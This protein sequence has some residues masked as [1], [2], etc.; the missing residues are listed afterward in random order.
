MI[1][2]TVIEYLSESLD[3]PVSIEKPCEVN[4]YVLIE[5]IGSSEENKIKTTTIAIQSYAETMYRAAM[6][7]EE[8]KTAMEGLNNIKNISKVQFN[9]DYNYTDTATKEYR[10]QAIYDLVYME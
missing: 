1:E 4:T 9:T 3:V 10:Y 7:N 8:V 2:C 5:K 6:L